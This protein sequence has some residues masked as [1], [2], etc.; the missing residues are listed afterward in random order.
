MTEYISELIEKIKKGDFD[1]SITG[2]GVEFSKE[3]DLAEPFGEFM[4]EIA[5]GKE[6]LFSEFIVP[7][8]MDIYKGIHPEGE[9]VDYLSVMALKVD[10]FNKVMEFEKNFL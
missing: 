9:G 4:F 7:S 5:M 6:V 10:I 2:E 1:S 3:D 8:S